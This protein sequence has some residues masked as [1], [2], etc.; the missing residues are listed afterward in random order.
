MHRRVEAVTVGA[1]LGMFRESTAWDAY[2]GAAQYVHD[3]Q[4]VNTL[5]RSNYILNA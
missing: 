4:A 1:S 3:I 2:V 5:F